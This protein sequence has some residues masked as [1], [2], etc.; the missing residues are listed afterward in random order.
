MKTFAFVSLLAFAVPA[1]AQLSVGDPWVRATVSAQKSTGAFM[2]LTAQ[3]DTRLVEAKSPVASVVQIHE[4]SMEGG[5]MKMSELE[6][7]LVLP[8]G[9]TLEFKPGGYHIMLQGLQQQIKEGDIVPLALTI[10]SADKKRSTIEVKAVARALTS[11]AH[12]RH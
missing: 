3:Q 5:L 10:E 6:K 11:P 9:K 1:F 2:Q 12:Q 8:A 7:G 4:M